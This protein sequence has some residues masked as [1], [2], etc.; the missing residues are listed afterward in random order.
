MRR[1]ARG[2]RGHGQAPRARTAIRV[3]VATLGVLGASAATAAE[4]P[5]LTLA[6][7][8]RAELVA[9]GLGAPRMLALDSSGTLLV[10]IPGRDAL[11]PFRRPRRP[12]R[13][14]SPVTVAEGLRLPHG[15][16]VRDGHLWVA[17]T[18][19]VLRFRYDTATR[20]AT[21]PVVIVPDLPPDAHHWTR[22]IAFGPDGRLYVAIG[23]S[24]DICREA[25]RRRAAIVSYAADGSGERLV[26]Q[27]APEPGRA[28][29]RPDDPR[30]VDV[31]ER[32][33][34]ARRRRAA[35]LSR[36]DARR[37]QL[38]LARLLR[39]R[40]ARSRPIPSFAA[41]SDCR[42][43]TLPSIELPPHAAP[44]GLA[45]YTGTQFPAAYRR[46]LFVALHGSRA[47]LAPAGYKI[48]RMISPPTGR[49]ESRTSRRVGVRAIGYG[50]ALSTCSSERDG[51]LYV[52]DDHGGRVLRIT[53][54]RDPG[55]RSRRGFRSRARASVQRDARAASFPCGPLARRARSRRPGEL[56]LDARSWPRP[57]HHAA[58]GRLTAE[59]TRTRATRRST[60][61]RATTWAGSA[62][63]GAG[64][65]RTRR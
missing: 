51:A 25:D 11:S 48:V 47:E 39:S 38:R 7:G 63:R 27:R 23:S 31:R 59:P 19:R 16:L 13:L 56:H 18:G 61:S 46:S 20:R 64:R 10:S 34:L 2:R 12:A 52:S 5:P 43:L 35:G 21:E 42:D 37:R 58:N 4:P 55:D 44:L 24:C 53:S 15:L 54:C 33:G 45:F 14:R 28:R 9:D 49:H 6:A 40:A 22:S 26:A 1:H 29:V 36:P 57:F 8:F 62:S 60:R 30:V 3:F 65:L 41:T 32:T 50:A 17:E